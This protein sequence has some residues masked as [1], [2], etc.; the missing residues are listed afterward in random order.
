MQPL[1]GV[2]TCEL[3][4]LS[5]GCLDIAVHV[6]VPLLNVLTHAHCARCVTCLDLQRCFVRINL[7]AQLIA[8]GRVLLYARVCAAA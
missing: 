1:L 4:Q 6:L 8:L 5:L 7:G 2:R 3:G